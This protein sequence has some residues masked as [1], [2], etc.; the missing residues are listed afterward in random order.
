MRIIT[1][2]ACKSEIEIT[3]EEVANFEVIE[4]PICNTEIYTG[5]PGDSKEYDLEE[6]LKF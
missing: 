1:C 5:D 2:F 4:C 3:E 6:E